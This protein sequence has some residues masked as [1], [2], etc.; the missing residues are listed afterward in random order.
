[1]KINNFYF[2]YVKRILDIICTFFTNIFFCL[3]YAILAILVRIKLGSPVL[4]IPNRLGKNWHEFKLY[5]FRSMTDA[6][7]KSG[8]LLL[9]TVRLTRFG[10]IMSAISLDELPEV[11]NIL[12]EDMSIIG[13][14]PMPILYKDFLPKKNGIGMIYDQVYQAGHRYMGETQFHGRII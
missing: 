12:L 3:L 7:D 9:D 8:N 14:R 10:R 11:I 4:Y 6:R 2:R 1:M 13:S 5:K